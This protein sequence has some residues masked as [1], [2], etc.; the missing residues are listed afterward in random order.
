MEFGNGRIA[1]PFA[2][3]WPVY[4]DYANA[5]GDTDRDAHGDTYGNTYTDSDDIAHCF[6]YRD[7][8]ANADSNRHADANPFVAPG[9]YAEPKAR[10][11]RGLRVPPALDRRQ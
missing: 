8:Y 1:D 3:T 6:P 11:P 10:K 5:Y 2:V 7:T 4:P 9:L